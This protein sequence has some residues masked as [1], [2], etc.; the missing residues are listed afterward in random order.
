VF[1]ISNFDP[2]RFKQDPTHKKEALLIKQFTA[3]PKK[4]KQINQQG[5][6]KKHFS[7]DLVYKF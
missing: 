5:V 4:S 6:P 3:F 1:S 2:V 7:F